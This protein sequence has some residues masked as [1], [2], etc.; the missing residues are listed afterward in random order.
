MTPDPYAGRPDLAEYDRMI[1]TIGMYQLA[2]RRGSNTLPV[3]PEARPEA[4]EGA[5]NTLR[6]LAMMLRKEA[7]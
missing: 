5:A 3:P 2:L 1:R 7:A 6:A 4:L